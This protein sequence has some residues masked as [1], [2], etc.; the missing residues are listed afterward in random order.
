MAVSLLSKY[1]AELMG[2][3]M[4]MIMLF[5]TI[6][7]VPVPGLPTVKPF[8]CFD[9]GVEFFIVLSAIG[10]SYSLNKNSSTI[11]FYR[12]RV[13]RIIPAFLIV[14]TLDFIA[15]DVIL[16][17]TPPNLLIYLKRV[18]FVS[19]FEGDISFWFI[20]Y[21]MLCYMLTPFVYKR[22]ESKGIIGL[23]TI[24]TL[25]IFTYGF[26]FNNHN[27]LLYRLPIYFISLI[28]MFYVLN[29][30]RKLNFFGLGIFAIAIYVSL[31]LFVH[32]PYKYLLY[33]VAAI[34]CL[35][36]V[37]MTMDK[38]K[39]KRLL[40]VF[41]F[42]GTISLELY[43]IHEKCLFFSDMISTNIAFRVTFSFT[44]AIALSYL[45]HKGLAWLLPT[46]RT[47]CIRTSH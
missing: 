7:G 37:A 47:Q 25:V 21:I 23:L 29:S 26:C 22:R 12:R 6:G 5:H 32:Y 39:N 3:S 18:L 40:T 41:S 19:F 8:I 38:I 33:M 13:K 27:L 2:F 15:H 43:L 46:T 30:Q 17:N 44:I 4:L 28:W 35:L 42:I 11:E 45:L 24:I 34:P 16:S 31:I 20:L 10:C 14:L 9:F 1:R 36:F